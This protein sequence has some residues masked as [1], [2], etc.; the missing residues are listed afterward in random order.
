MPK[1]IKLG[2]RKKN[3]PNKVTATARERFKLLLDSYDETKMQEDLNSLS[4]KDR[5]SF[6]SDIAEFVIPKLSRT[7][8]QE[9]SQH[10]INWIVQKTYET[11][12]EANKGVRLSE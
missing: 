9:N 7:E 3:T 5:L 6:I 1:G 8:I 11:K 2:G 10:T 4:P 12:L